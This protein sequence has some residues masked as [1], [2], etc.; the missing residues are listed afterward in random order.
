MESARKTY[1]SMLRH[2]FPKIRG[3]HTFLPIVCPD[4]RI[5][6]CAAMRVYHSRKKNS[7]GPNKFAALCTRLCRAQ[8]RAPRSFAPAGQG[9]SC[10]DSLHLRCNRLELPDDAPNKNSTDKS[11]CCF[12]GAPIR[13]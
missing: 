5:F 2:I 1:L 4:L 13:A 6:Q 7:S 11:L 10:P 8:G 12:C 9:T 3:E